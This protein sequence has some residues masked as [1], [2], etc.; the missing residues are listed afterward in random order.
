M[1]VV[2][3]DSVDHQFGNGTRSP[4]RTF[5]SIPGRQ[6]REGLDR[7]SVARDGLGPLPPVS[8]NI[9][10]P[11]PEIGGLFGLLGD[12][13]PDGRL[14]GDDRGDAFGVAIIQDVGLL[15]VGRGLFGLSTG[16]V[17]AAALDPGQG[18]ERPRRG[19]PR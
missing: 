5:W 12:D 15:E 4:Q 14:A 17:E 13:P 2:A 7:M 11:L 3:V 19:S 6:G 16:G 1:L 9:A 10:A 8:E 18:V